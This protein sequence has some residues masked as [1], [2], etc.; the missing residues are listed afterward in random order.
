[1][2]SSKRHAADS[3]FKA[4]YLEVTFSPWVLI[5]A[6]HYSG[7]IAPNHQSMRVPQGC[8][9]EKML[10]HGKVDNWI[11]AITDDDGCCIVF[12]GLGLKMRKPALHSKKQSTRGEPV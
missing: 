10:F 1:M 8:S 3:R 2:F 11:V 5:P 6:Y 9:F 12:L 7:M 4:K